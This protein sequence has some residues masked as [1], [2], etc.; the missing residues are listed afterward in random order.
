MVT[1]DSI[2]SQVYTAS[3]DASIAGDQYFKQYF[4]FGKGV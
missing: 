1:I 3:E 2:D 4:F